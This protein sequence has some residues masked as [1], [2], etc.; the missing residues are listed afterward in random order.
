MTS[1]S[2]DSPRDD[3]AHAG[4]IGFWVAIIL[5]ALLGLHPPGST[6]LYGDG[7]AFLEHIDG[8]WI[9]IHIAVAVLLFVIPLVV[10][11]WA[12]HLA[13]PKA[14]VYGGLATYAA[15]GGAAVGVIHLVG[16]DTMTFVAFS[17][18]FESGAGSEAVLVGADILLRIHAAT[19]AA[20]ALSFFF[21]LPVSA[22]IAAIAD[23][24]YPVWYWLLLLV[25]GAAALSGVI[26]AFGEGQWSDLSETV[27]LRVSG[28]LAIA[29]ILIT[30]WWM[31]KGST[32]PA[33]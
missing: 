28:V 4:R 19:L 30:S 6:E 24:R 23:G 25:A 16:I 33:P 1:E 7:G 5:A 27:L 17:D 13:T 3:I 32:A 9:A 12:S 29:W 14:R 18:T 8:F 2:S 10:G 31:R 21:V 15:I 22:G 11:V 20:W 26:V